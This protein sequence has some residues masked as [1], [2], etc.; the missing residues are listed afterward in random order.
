MKTFYYTL[1]ISLTLLS[2]ASCNTA[3]V[4]CTEVDKFQSRA[5]ILNVPNFT[6]GDIFMIDT[7]AKRGDYLMH[8]DILDNELSISPKIDST[9]ILTNTSFSIAFEGAIEKA[10]QSVKVD[11]SN[12]IKNNTTFFMTNHFRKN[13]KTPSTKI[14]DNQVVKELSTISLSNS[15]IVFGMVT[16][17]VYAD[18]FEFRVKKSIQAGGKSNV[19]KSGKFKINV[20]YECEGSVVVDA[21]NGGIFFKVTVFEYDKSKNK[22]IA[23]TGFDLSKYEL[24]G[25]K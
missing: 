9:E 3:R 17:I 23:R 12:K 18:D 13:I 11:A 21:K 19:I 4:A 25:A 14:N 6:Q 22:L 20:N 16:G 8:I 1:L 10:S 2:F 15:N 24:V 7:L 5:G